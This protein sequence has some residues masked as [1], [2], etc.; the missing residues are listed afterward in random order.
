MKHARKPPPEFPAALKGKLRGVRHAQ[1]LRPDMNAGQGHLERESSR[2]RSSHFAGN[3]MKTIHAVAAVAVLATIA[4]VGALGADAPSR[5]P[6]VSAQEWAP[7]SDTLGVVLEQPLPPAGDADGPAAQPSVD[8]Q[9]QRL[10]RIG[11]NRTVPG[12]VLGAALI[13]PISGYLMVKRGNAW[14]RVIL[15]EPVK[16]P[17]PAG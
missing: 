10:S 11:G 6:G 4:I 12:G 5:P 16:G 2:L 7:I 15:V 13:P 8:G 1:H 9:D 17:G 3:A 14:Q